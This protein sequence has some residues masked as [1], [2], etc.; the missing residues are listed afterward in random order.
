MLHRVAETRPAAFSPNGYLT[1]SPRFL[2]KLLL[3]LKHRGFEFVSMD[4]LLNRLRSYR[5]RRWP[6]PILAVTL[7]DGYRDNLENAVPVFRRHSVPYTIYVAPGLVDGQATLWWEDLAAIIARRDRFVLKSPKGNVDFDVSTTARK[8]KAFDELMALLTHK[9]SEDEQRT[10]VAELAWQAGVDQEAHRA[11]SIMN[12]SEIVELSR[13]PLCT[14]GAHTLRH[15]ALARLDAARAMAEIDESGRIIGIETGERP[16]HFAYPYGGPAA[17]GNREFM[18][19]REAGFDSAVTTRHG[20]LYPGHVEHM[21]A[22]PR[23]SLNGNFQAMRYVD[24]LLSG[25]P[26]RLVNKGRSLNVA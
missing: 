3:R 18:F 21:H 7:D 26:T 22:L 6:E 20:V 24:T 5:P 10:I 2:D 13:D 25:L 12:W 9:V 1:V 4:E 16:R 23:I 14:I 19:A 17:A 11:S 8:N 15:F